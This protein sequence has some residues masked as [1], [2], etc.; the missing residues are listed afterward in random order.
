MDKY[1][2]SKI[3]QLTRDNIK[4]MLKLRMAKQN[5]EKA[6]KREK[7]LLERLYR[8]ESL[9]ASKEVLEDDVFYDQQSWLDLHPDCCVFCRGYKHSL[10]FD[11]IQDLDEYI[12]RNVDYRL[13][14]FCKIAECKA[15]CI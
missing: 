9:K 3:K 1:K 4:L 12:Q 2:T 8:A 11:C 14:E 5:V 10:K 15:Y 7:L 13:C 6:Q